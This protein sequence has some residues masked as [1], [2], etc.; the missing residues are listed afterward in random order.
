MDEYG[1][2]LARLVLMQL[3]RTSR[4]GV[5]R[6]E[7]LREARLSEAQ[8]ADPDA[9]VP[10]AAYA[11]LWRATTSRLS[12]PALGL[13][14]GADVRARE[15]GLVGYTMAHSGTLA[16]ALR[17]FARY[18]R[19][20]SD[21]LVVH[22]EPSPEASWIRL[23]VQPALRAY[24][25]AADARLAAVLTV[26]R[27]ITRTPIVPLSVQF[28]Y[29]RPADTQEY[30]RFF[31]A[32]LEFGALA[33]GFLLAHEDMARPVTSS[34]EVLTGYLESLATQLVS[35]LGEERG[36]RD[37][38]RRMLWSEMSEGL[39]DLDRIARTFG[40]SARTFQRRLRAEKTT[41]ATVLAELRH[42]MAAPLLRDGRLAVSE[43]AFLTGYEDAGSFCR[44][45]RRRTGLSPRAYRRV[46]P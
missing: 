20:L 38:L 32:P 44:A 10:V 35:K 19:I 1:C 24:R 26:C 14:F 3:E 16:S 40:M 11:R 7:L 18:G 17:R 31:R 4:L 46:G 37:R 45:F 22:V 2:G 15:F 6:A 36:L 43:V 9:R 21:T 42:D 41:F 5:S 27:E 23:D 25:Q 13:R 33:T 30:E 39:P 28:P 29:R 34:D 12:D 8:L